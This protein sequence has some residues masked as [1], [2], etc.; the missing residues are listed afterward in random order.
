MESVE[1][2]SDRFFGDPNGSSIVAQRV[3]PVPFPLLHTTTPSPNRLT[4]AISG[5]TG[6]IPPCVPTSSPLRRKSSQ[7]EREVQRVGREGKLGRRAW[8]AGPGAIKGLRLDR[9]TETAQGG[10]EEGQLGN[11]CTALKHPRHPPS[12]PPTWRDQKS[13]N[14]GK[15]SWAFRSHSKSSLLRATPPDFEPCEDGPQRIGDVEATVAAQTL[16]RIAGLKPAVPRHVGEE[17]CLAGGCR[18]LHR[19]AERPP[20]RWLA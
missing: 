14:P 20:C 5:L 16:R 15:T 9:S 13:R 3:L 19:I 8:V 11:P 7:R 2:R 1:Y 12:S 6:H 4:E 17:A 10:E 18:K